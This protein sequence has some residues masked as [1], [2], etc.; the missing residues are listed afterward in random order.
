MGIEYEFQQ[1]GF[2]DI[3]IKEFLLK[4]GVYPNVLGFNYLIRAVEIVGKKGKMQVTNELYPKIAEEF[5]T[6]SGKVERAI[7]H[8]ISDKIKMQNFKQIGIYDRPTN[9]QLIYYFAM[10]NGGENWWVNLKNGQ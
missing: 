10:N 9:S 3:S 5:K 6:T 2:Y 7:R 4:S 1:S 8:I